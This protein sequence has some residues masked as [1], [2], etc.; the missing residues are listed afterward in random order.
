MRYRGYLTI[1]A[2]GNA[3][4]VRFHAAPFRVKAKDDDGKDVAMFCRVS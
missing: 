1:W 2:N 3:S 4:M